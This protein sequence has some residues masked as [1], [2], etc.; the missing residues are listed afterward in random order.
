MKVPFLELKPGYDELRG[1]FDAAHHRV[2]DSGSA[3]LGE[4]I[5]QFK[6]EFAAYCRA[7]F[8]L[9]LGNGLDAL[10]LILRAHAI[11]AGDEA[12]QGPRLYAQPADLDPIPSVARK[13][14][15][16]VTEDNARA[17]GATY[18]SRRTG[19]LGDAAASSFYPVKSLDAF[20]GAGALTPHLCGAYAQAGWKSADFPVGEE[21]AN[22]ELSLPLDPH[23]EPE[24]QEVALQAIRQNCVQS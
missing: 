12:R 13:H 2:M 23:L 9:T 16:K 24:T 15:L 21:I 7:D 19:S 14:S 20:G 22:T 1:E 4:E 5:V 11:G 8:C 17:Y 3:V 10:H 18:K 6:A